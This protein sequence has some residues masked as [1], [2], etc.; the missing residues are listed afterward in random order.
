[1]ATSH[2]K[3]NVGPIPEMSCVCNILQTADIIQHNIKKYT[4]TRC[5]SML[6]ETP[7]GTI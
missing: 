3:S 7:S 2:M 4:K 6:V 5:F 1:M